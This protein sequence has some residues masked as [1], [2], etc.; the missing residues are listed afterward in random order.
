MREKVWKGFSLIFIV[1][2]AFT[3]FMIFSYCLSG[4]KDEHF[5]EHEL[6]HP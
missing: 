2:D 3:T 1:H 6:E 5:E 4:K